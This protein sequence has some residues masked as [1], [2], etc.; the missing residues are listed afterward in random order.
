MAITRR[1]GWSGNLRESIVFIVFSF[2]CVPFLHSRLPSFAASVGRND[3]DLRRPRWRKTTTNVSSYFRLNSSS[4][5]IGLVRELSVLTLA[6][7]GFA[8]LEQT[9]RAIQV[10]SI[11]ILMNRLPRR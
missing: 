5:R 4:A 2:R 10:M 1:D 7:P 8:I 9:N 6:L 3:V 11:F